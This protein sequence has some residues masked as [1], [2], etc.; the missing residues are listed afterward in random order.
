VSERALVDVRAEPRVARYRA[1]EESLWRRYGIQPRERFV[2]LAS[3]RA[4]IRIL[5]AGTGPA[6]LLVH[7]SGPPGAAS[8][9]APLVAELRGFRSIMVDLPG[10]GLSAP[11]RRRRGDYAIRLADLLAGLLTELGVERAHVMG[12]SIGGIWS[13]RLAQRHPE[14]VDRM[15]QMA[16][17]PI[18]AEVKPP[19]SIRIMSTPIGAM[20]AGLPA[21]PAVVRSLLRR[22]VGHGASLDAGRIAPELIDWIVA[23]MRHTDTARNERAWIPDLIG[24][25]GARPSLGF[26]E[27]EV[28]SIGKRLLYVY[29]S[30]D[31]PG[32]PEVA[33]RTV[34][35]LPTS[36]VVVVPDGGHAPWLDDPSGVAR[37]VRRFLGWSQ[38]GDAA[39]TA[40]P[41]P[42]G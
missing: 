3:D 1:A 26:T 39:V 21:T 20:L 22:V 31:W 17:S 24:W 23:L 38:S 9:W 4:R 13:L 25:G 30:A 10:A 41:A 5:E 34:G 32:T 14:R 33:Q 42:S 28:A 2:G 27:R 12:W 11:L 35:L 15:V 29:G 6:L 36:R 7:G 19:A 40:R 16:F 37:S 18:W 8:A